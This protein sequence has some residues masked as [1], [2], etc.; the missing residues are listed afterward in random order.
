MA[1]RHWRLA[2]RSPCHIVIWLHRR[3][4]CA[5]E[6]KERERE[7]SESCLNVRSHKWNIPSHV[8]CWCFG[9]VPW[10]QYNRSITHSWPLGLLASNTS[11][12]LPFQG[13]GSAL[14]FDSPGVQFCLLNQSFFKSTFTFFNHAFCL[15]S[16]D[17]PGYS[18]TYS[19]PFP[20]CGHE[21]KNAPGSLEILHHR[22]AAED[23]VTVLFFFNTRRKRLLDFKGRALS[24][25]LDKSL[26]PAG[27]SEW[28]SCG[29]VP[30]QLRITQDPEPHF[31]Q[32][33]L[34]KP[35]Y[36]TRFWPSG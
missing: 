3:I 18:K 31:E 26:Y 23:A 13:G 8:E 7:R 11:R 6:E 32:P 5:L 4:A 22:N 29:G 28:F 20:G 21:P 14:N 35:S 19:T 30:L 12:F 17:S 15:L 9:Y 10:P 16:F 27:W 33:R 24:L 34:A 36:W 25:F 1:F 2:P